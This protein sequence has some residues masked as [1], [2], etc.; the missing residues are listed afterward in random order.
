MGADV[1]TGATVTFGTSGLAY[2]ILSASHGGISR[3]SVPTSHLGT[4]G[5][6]TFI[7]G[8]LYDPGTLDIEYLLRPDDDA[9]G[10]EIPINLAAETITLTFPTR[11]GTA[12][13]VAGSGFCTDWSYG[14]P[15]EDRMTGQ[16]SIKFSGS[17][18]YANAAA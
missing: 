4:T 8:D 9:L 7:P 13:N 5:G 1:G 10:T 16:M 6:M 15:F 12:A 2:H 3:A 11:L 14:T 17:L 18:T